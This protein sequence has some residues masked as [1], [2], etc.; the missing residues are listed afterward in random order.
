MY[1]AAIRSF[2]QEMFSSIPP[3][4]VM[5]I[6][7]ILV[8]AFLIY[9]LMLIIHSTSAARVARSIML[10]LVATWLTDVVHM[11]TLNWILT[12]FIEVGIIA[13]VIVF[14]PE[15]RRALERFGGRTMLRFA[16]PLSNRSV[17]QNAIAAT[18]TACEIMAKERVGV[19]LVFER[20]TSLE[21]YFK[22]GT[23][24]DAKVTDQLLRNLFFKN[25]PLHDGA[26]I[27]RH[28]RVAAAG[29]VL[30]L[31]ENTH[32]SSDLGTRHRAGIGMSEASD[33]VVV[34][35]SEETGTISVAI[36]GMLKRHLAPQTLEKLLTNELLPE[37][38]YKKKNVLDRVR[39]FLAR[40]EEAH[41]EEK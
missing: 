16:D 39:S 31:S 36:G 14:Q 26:V 28:G 18:V 25:S 2:F 11:Y 24:I 29:C 35:V 4:G 15:L 20:R 33:A 3:L 40:K 10:L 41:H 23:L 12:R 32:L 21:E 13:I 38:N 19:L 22:T 37:E 7:D 1:M 6:V 34:I 30:P 27:I 5:D 17:E 8:V 9:K